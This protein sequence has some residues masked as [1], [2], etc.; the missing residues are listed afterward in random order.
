MRIHS[1]RNRILNLLIAISFVG[2]FPQGLFANVSDTL[3]LE[4]GFGY[5]ETE[6]DTD[7]AGVNTQEDDAISYYVNASI[8]LAPG[9]FVIPELGVLDQR[10]SALGAD[11]AKTTYFGAKFQINF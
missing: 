5:I 7:V 4:A 2:V 9:V 11:E 3:T 10:D 6:W 8:T 1:I